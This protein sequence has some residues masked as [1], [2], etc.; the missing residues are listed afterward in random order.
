MCAKRNA[1]QYSFGQGTTTS[2]QDNFTNRRWL[3]EVALKEKVET[4]YTNRF[5]TK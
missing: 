4:D 1:P 3:Y 5:L 2:C